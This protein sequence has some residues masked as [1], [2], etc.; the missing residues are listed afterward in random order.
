ML[1]EDTGRTREMPSVW[2]LKASSP[3]GEPEC[4]DRQPTVAAFF[5]T[6]RDTAFCAHGTDR[7]RK[8]G[9]T[10]DRGEESAF[11]VRLALDMSVFAPLGRTPLATR[12][13]GRRSSPTSAVIVGHNHSSRPHRG[14]ELLLT[15][16]R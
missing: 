1:A 14:R 15:P 13:P 11:D 12:P 3:Y 7:T 16:R 8:L 6:W 4:R 10:Q 2:A 9:A 5:A